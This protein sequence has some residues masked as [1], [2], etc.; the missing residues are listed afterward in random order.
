[1][2]SGIHAGIDTGIDAS[3]QPPAVKA[4]MAT[5]DKCH[6]HR[7]Y[8]VTRRPYE[9]ALRFL[10]LHPYVC[11]RCGRRALMAGRYHPFN[12][13]RLR[14]VITVRSRFLKSPA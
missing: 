10:G 13:R 3:A 5:C 1:M 8:R 2:K 7:L 12:W 9:K 14:I 11:D 6:S 4:R